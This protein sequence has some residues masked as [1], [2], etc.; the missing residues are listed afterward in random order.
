MDT[1]WYNRLVLQDLHQ[2]ALSEGQLMT[3]AMV[4][5]SP[6]AT[7]HLLDSGLPSLLTLALLGLCEYYDTF[8]VICS[9]TV[10]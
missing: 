9:L 3:V 5:Q 2:L 4:C 1:E 10:T 7:R 8:L 6:P